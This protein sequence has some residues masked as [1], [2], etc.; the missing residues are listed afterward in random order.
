MK[1][2]RHIIN[3]ENIAIEKIMGFTP[4]TSRTDTPLFRAI[5]KIADERH[6]AQLVPTVAG[7]F[8]DS[9]FFRDLGITSYG[10]SPFIFEASEATGVHGNNERISVS[11]ITNGVESFYQLLEEFTVQR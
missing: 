9:H 6:G 8:T 2:L 4:A 3:D 7:G 11:N 10:Y 5:Q 1:E